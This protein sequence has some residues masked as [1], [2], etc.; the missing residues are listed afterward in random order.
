MAQLITHTDP[1]SFHVTYERGRNTVRVV[2][3]TATS[4]QATT[5]TFYAEELPDLI[6][7]LTEAHTMLSRPAG[8]HDADEVAEE[9]ASA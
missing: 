3:Y 4:V 7:Q 9:P 6:R 5:I 1:Y 2:G 8:G